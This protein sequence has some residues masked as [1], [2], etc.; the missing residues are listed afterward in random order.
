MLGPGPMPKECEGGLAAAE[1]DVYSWWA[2]ESGEADGPGVFE[3]VGE[4]EKGSTW[5]TTT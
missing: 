1:D 4:K 2:F 5:G 3:L